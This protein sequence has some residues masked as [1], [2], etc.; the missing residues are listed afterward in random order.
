MANETLTQADAGKAVELKEG[1]VIS[2][3][4]EENP[5]TGYRWAVDELDEQVLELQSSD[6]V[7]AQGGGAGAAGERRL[8][9][10]A[11]RAGTTALRLQ[12]RREW[13]KENPAGRYSVKVTVGG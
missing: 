13:E 4:L 1:D 3:R 12:Y 11:K 9:F 8:T 10:R 5:T 7:G 6:F 2:V